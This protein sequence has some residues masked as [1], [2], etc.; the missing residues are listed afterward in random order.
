ML[1]GC[2]TSGRQVTYCKYGLKFGIPFAM[3]WDLCWD[4]VGAMLEWYLERWHVV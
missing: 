1:V 2:K 4:G 3:E